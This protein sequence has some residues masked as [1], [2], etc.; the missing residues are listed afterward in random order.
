MGLYL[1]SFSPRFTRSS[2][3]F[4]WAHPSSLRNATY[5]VLDLELTLKKDLLEVNQSLKLEPTSTQKSVER[6]LFRTTRRNYRA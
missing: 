3:Y 2:W 4:R 5:S 1:V 6:R